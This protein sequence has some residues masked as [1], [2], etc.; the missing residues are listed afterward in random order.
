MTQNAAVVPEL[1][2]QRKAAIAHAAARDYSGSV[3]VEPMKQFDLNRTIF[4]TLEGTL[5]RVI[6][7]SRI[8]KDPQ[9]RPDA[10]QTI[11]GAYERVHAER[12]RAILAGGDVAA[13]GWQESARPRCHRRS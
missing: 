8:A 1:T 7:Q 12:D 11:D 9:W 13:S 4:N 2:V 10:V 5:Q 3:R 6:I